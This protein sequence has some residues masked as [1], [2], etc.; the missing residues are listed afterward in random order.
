MPLLWKTIIDYIFYEAF[1]GLNPEMLS[2]VLFDD[3]YIFG[4]LVKKV[5]CYAYL[6]PYLQH[7]IKFNTIGTVFMNRKQ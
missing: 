7:I 4:D 6:G 1:S 5:M 2:F 3:M